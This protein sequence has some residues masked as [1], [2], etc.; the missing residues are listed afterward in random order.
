MTAEVMKE[1]MSYEDSLIMQRV[2]TRLFIEID[3]PGTA[4]K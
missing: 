2:A 3:V 4:R 1:N